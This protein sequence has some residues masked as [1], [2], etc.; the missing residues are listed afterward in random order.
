[1]L[2]QIHRSQGDMWWT[3]SCLRLRDFAMTW[4]DYQW[5]QTHDLSQLNS[6]TE[7]ERDHFEEKAVWLC[8]RCEDVGLRN[9]RKLARLAQDEQRL[10]HQIK[11]LHSNKTAA[12]QPSSAFQGL[13]SVINV[14][15]RSKVMICRNVAY[16]Y[17][18][19]NGT[20]G[21]VVGVVYQPGAAFKEGQQPPFP[22]A[23]IVD[24]AD[25]TGPVFYPG[26]PTWVP[27]LPMTARR[28]NTRQTREQFPLVAGFA[29]T[30]NKAQGLTMKEG[31]VINLQGSKR[32]RP[33]S[34]HGLAFVAF[35][36][37]ESFAMTAFKNLP[38][39]NDFVHGQSSGL[40]RQRLH[41]TE[42]L[43]N[44][45][46]R[47]TMSMHSSMH[48]ESAEQAAQDAWREERCKRQRRQ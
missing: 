19:A 38:P 5:W 45:L 31:V 40:L 25:Y 10:I 18:L 32:F 26:H 6:F 12:K 35:T 2:E 27:I 46:H 3:E 4:D 14:V 16:R 13:R 29:L 30:V 39:W 37:S 8:A 21:F 24:V 44:K 7:Q 36:R 41:F 15:R 47:K 42:W 34:K 33:A 23:I 28:E 20:R 43:K 22:E 1:M 48:T 9:G 11:A 17:G